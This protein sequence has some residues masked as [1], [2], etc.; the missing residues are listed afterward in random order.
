MERRLQELSQAEEP[1]AEAKSDWEIIQ[2]IA[3][4]MGGAMNY[5]SPKDVLAEIRSVVPQCRDLAPGACWPAELSPIAGTDADL[6]LASG[7][8]MKDEVITSDRLL[9][10]SGMTI[11]RSQEISTIRR[12]KVATG[13]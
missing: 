10:S 6:S 1:L 9:F 3:R 7:T 2:L 12:V 13:K 11:T 4:K 5:A 8:I